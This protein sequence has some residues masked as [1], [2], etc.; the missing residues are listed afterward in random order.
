MQKK[1]GK[2]PNHF[3]FAFLKSNIEMDIFKMWIRVRISNSGKVTNW[4]IWKSDLKESETLSST[5]CLYFITLSMHKP[6]STESLGH[7]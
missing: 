6:Y 2:V 5:I 3:H 1:K 7:F 4:K